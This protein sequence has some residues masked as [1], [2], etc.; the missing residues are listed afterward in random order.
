MFKTRSIFEYIRFIDIIDFC[1]IE[2]S[3]EIINNILFTF[4][5][6]LNKFFICIQNES[7]SL[8]YLQFLCPFD[9]L[10]LTYQSVV[11]SFRNNQDILQ[12][13]VILR[14]VRSIQYHF[15]L[16]KFMCKIKNERLRKFY[17]IFSNEGI[18]CLDSLFSRFYGFFWWSTSLRL[19]R[20]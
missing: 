10:W 4:I 19:K 8:F 11:L 18:D 5:L 3:I 9:L 16:D 6:K 13:M 2:H 1:I 7:F 15:P 12:L 17:S 20:R 14:M